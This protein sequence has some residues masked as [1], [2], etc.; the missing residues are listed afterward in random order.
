[1]SDNRQFHCRQE[2][3]SPWEVSKLIQQ[4]YWETYGGSPPGNYELYL[5][6]TLFGPWAADLI[7][8]AELRPGERV[9]DVA[10]G[11]GV[12]ARHASEAVGPAGKVVGVDLNPS[13]LEVAR[14]VTP[15]GVEWQQASAES[16]PFPDRAFDL[17]LCQQGVQFFP[18]RPAALG[19][20][21]RVLAP[22]GRLALLVNGRIERC[23]PML[24]LDEVLRTHMGPAAAAFLDA[25]FSQGTA[26]ELRDL[27]T[28]TGFREVTIR[29]LSRIMRLPPPEE[30]LWQYVGSTPLMSFA[31]QMEDAARSTLASEFVSKCERYLTGDGLAMPIELQ[32]ATAQK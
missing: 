23:P 6:P 4:A 27:I 20:M 9:L 17:V 21:H 11:T 3:K 7:D 2:K 14:S 19:E 16:M 8:L 5:V 24:V 30:F 10:C 13:M 15:S 32:L 12:V 29:L 22:G 31:G 26:E 18:N 1:L 28:G 25:V